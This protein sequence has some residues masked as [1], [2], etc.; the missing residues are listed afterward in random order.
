MDFYYDELNI[1]LPD[2]M[3]MSKINYQ[4]RACFMRRDKWVTN[5]LFR[6]LLILRQSFIQARDRGG[7]Y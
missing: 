6:M 4:D 2:S 5:A 3:R 1:P 7:G